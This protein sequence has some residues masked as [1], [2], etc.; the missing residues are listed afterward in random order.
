MFNYGWH[1]KNSGAE[2]RLNFGGTRAYLVRYATPLDR[3]FDEQAAESHFMRR[4]VTCALLMSGFG[5][6]Q[7]EPA[8]RVMF[9]DVWGEQVNWTA[10]IDHPD[11]EVGAMPEQNTE[12]LFGWI[13]ALSL[14]T[15]LRRAAEDAHAAQR[16]CE[17]S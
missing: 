3:D 1:E 5:L 12:V 2:W 8:G 4:R 10:Y 14:H 15:P 11:P 9:T 7:A 13:R 6:F 16:N 17:E